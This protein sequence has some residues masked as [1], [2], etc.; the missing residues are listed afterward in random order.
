MKYPKIA[1]M[2]MMMADNNQTVLQEGKYW[3]LLNKRRK[4]EASR[5]KNLMS[6]IRKSVSSNGVH[7]IAGILIY[8]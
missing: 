7:F 1:S 6:K 5:P 3:E 2:V 4:R 8:I